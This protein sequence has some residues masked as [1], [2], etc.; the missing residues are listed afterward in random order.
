MKDNKRFYETFKFM[1]GNRKQLPKF[2]L[3]SLY[4]VVI[5]SHNACL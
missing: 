2:C 1:N 5:N 3:L 4:I